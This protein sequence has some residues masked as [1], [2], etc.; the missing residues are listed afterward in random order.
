MSDINNVVLVGRLTRDPE[1]RKTNTGKSVC[2][3]SVATNRRKKKD[4]ESQADYVNCVAWE[5]SADYLTQFGHKGDI[6]TVT[7]RIQSRK[8]DDSEGR[9]VFVQEVLAQDVSLLKSAENRS[10]DNYMRGG[11]SVSLR[12]FADQITDVEPERG[13]VADD[14]GDDYPF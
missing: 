5:Q 12:E 13:N 10:Q 1:L 7:G 2:S 11:K 3:F 8:Y 4:E 6:V 9:T 14:L